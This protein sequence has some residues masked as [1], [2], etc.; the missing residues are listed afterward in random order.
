MPVAYFDP[1]SGAS[2]D[3]ILGAL[4]DAG[5]ALDDL[6]GMLAGLDLSGYELAAER[7]T[8][9]GVSGTRVSVRVAGEQQARSWRDIR[10][11]IERAAL[12]DPVRQHALAVFAA[13]A[14]AEGRVHGVPADAVH[15]HE[16]GA[17]DS[18][19][20]VVGAAAG[21]QLLGVEAVY[22]GPL[23]L[24]SGFVSTRH[25]LLPVPAPATA[26]LL[27]ASG[28]PTVAREIEAEL[29]TP[30]GAAVLT[31]LARF[32]RPA[33]HASAIGYG[34]GQRELPWPNALRLWLGELDPAA[35]PPGDDSGPSELLLE[36]NI[37]DMN[38]EFYE[39]LI[40]RLFAAGALDVFLTPIIMKRGRPA[41]QV[42]VIC[43]AADRAELDRVLIE[44]SSTLGVRA[45]PLD[46]T[47]AG[48]RVE[49]VVTRWGE[50]RVKLKIWRGRVLDAV[51]EYADCLA[52]AH[53][54]GMPIRYIYGEASRIAEAYVG[55]RMDESSPSPRIGRGSRGG[56]GSSSG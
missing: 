16:V 45:L 32:E 42:S 30:T 21:L 28:A 13:L 55:R 25:G 15:F 23:S 43:A 6:L 34:F 5:L 46:R 22:C 7:V 51:P 9:H 26:Q 8:Q 10:A 3:M 36:T 47:K 24:G 27:A 18:I 17:V 11:L 12:P 53:E 31:R 41:T 39:P 1:F 2:G 48:R 33:L 52:V 19:V 38:P 35:A 54:T 14:E 40:E 29:L 56:E 44:N 20:D 37:D 50:V 49:E 4:V